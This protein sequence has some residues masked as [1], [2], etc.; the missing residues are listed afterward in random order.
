MRKEIDVTVEDDRPIR[1]DTREK[2]ADGK[3]IGKPHPEV[4]KPIGEKSRDI[5][6]TYHIT[7]MPAT[8]AEKWA[9]RAL[10]AAGRSGVELP[11]VGNATGMAVIAILGIQAI[12]RIHFEDIEPL[13]DEMME[14]VKF[15][16]SGGA[17]R[18][19]IEDDIEEVRTYIWLRQKIIELHVGFSIGE[20]LFPAK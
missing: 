12:M 2:G 4:G 15:K 10:L 6:K 1:Q 16:A 8:K 3:L 5:G 17:I 9:M 14:C 13:L 7:E 11:D 19:L 18:D 20:S